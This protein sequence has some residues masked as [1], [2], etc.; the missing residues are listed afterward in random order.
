MVFI[1]WSVVE[2]WGMDWDSLTLTMKSSRVEFENSGSCQPTSVAN[3]LLPPDPQSAIIFGSSRYKSTGINVYCLQRHGFINYQCDLHETQKS[4]YLT[5]IQIK[6]IF[7]VPAS[8]SKL[9]SILTGNVN[10]FRCT[11]DYR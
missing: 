9:L 8:R 7:S 3:N 10:V 1:H 4:K 6:V 11:V 2:Q 5:E